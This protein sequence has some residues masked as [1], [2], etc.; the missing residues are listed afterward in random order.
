MRLLIERKYRI[1]GSVAPLR[2]GQTPFDG[3]V[4][5]LALAGSSSPRVESRG[6]AV[7]EQARCELSIPARAKSSCTLRVPPPG[8]GNAN[9]TPRGR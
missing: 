1:V 6:A 3:M 9:R 7:T 8:A 5:R 2:V 4:A